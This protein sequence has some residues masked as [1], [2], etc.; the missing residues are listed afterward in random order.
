[1]ALYQDYG[2]APSAARITV[3]NAGPLLANLLIEAVPPEGTERLETRLTLYA[4]LDRI[5]VESAFSLVDGRHE[6]TYD[7]PFN[8]PAPASF[9][10]EGPA[11]T[12]MVP[13]RDEFDEARLDYWNTY[14]FVDVSSLDY[15]ITLASPDAR[16]VY[17]GPVALPDGRLHSNLSDPYLLV[18]AIGGGPE[19]KDHFDDNGGPLDNPYCYRFSLMPHRGPVDPVH[20]LQRGWEALYPLLTEPVRL[21]AS[22]PDLPAEASFWRVPAPLV[23]SA[24]KRAEDGQEHEYMLRLWNP[25]ASG[26]V[27]AEITSDLFTVARARVNDHGERDIGP[28]L[29]IRARGFRITVPDSSYV[30]VRLSL[31]G[32]AVGG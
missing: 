21:A 19:D 22:T 13:G 18:R 15:G 30:T 16:Q 12:L 2:R 14:S 29:P 1:M 25:A 26:L 6:I 4:D 11:G 28:E 10:L 8:L 9:L 20:A 31:Q 3:E 7:W 27:E 32:P 5:D 23:V 17:M 24:F